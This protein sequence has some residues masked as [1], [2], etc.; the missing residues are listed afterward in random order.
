MSSALS[1]SRV[2][3]VRGCEHTN[4]PNFGLQEWPKANHRLSLVSLPRARLHRQL[5]EEADPVRGLE[6]EFLWPKDQSE[7]SAF[8]ATSGLATPHPDRVRRRAFQEG[9]KRPR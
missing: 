5:Q 6:Q 3:E 7:S 9:P 4:Q 2:P 1:A 8:G